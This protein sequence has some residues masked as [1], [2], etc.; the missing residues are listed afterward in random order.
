MNLF[1]FRKEFAKFGAVTDTYNTGK[2]CAFVTFEGEECAET[3]IKEMKEKT[4]LK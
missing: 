3:A 1:F 4:I 2:G